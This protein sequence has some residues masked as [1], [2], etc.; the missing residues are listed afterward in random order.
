VGTALAGG[1]GP[2]GTDGNEDRRGGDGGCDGEG[3]E[4]AESTGVVEDV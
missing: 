3:V 1:D 2:G 4:V